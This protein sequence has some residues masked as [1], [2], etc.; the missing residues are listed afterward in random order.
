MEIFEKFNTKYLVKQNNIY[1]SLKSLFYTLEQTK[2]DLEKEQFYKENGLYDINELSLK[3]T[4]KLIDLKL[5]D[6]KGTYKTVTPVDFNEI[7]DKIEYIYENNQKKI[8]YNTEEYQ[9]LELIKKELGCE[10][11]ICK[12][13]KV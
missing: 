7:T 10:F 6:T 4:S 1:Y 13:E 3:R 11:Q 9:L 5:T 8:K 2:N 12:W